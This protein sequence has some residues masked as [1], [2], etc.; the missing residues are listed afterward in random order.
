MQNV[1]SNL[2]LYSFHFF[3]SFVGF[4]QI[5]GKNA[6]VKRRMPLKIRFEAN[7]EFFNSLNLFFLSL[8]VLSKDCLE[9]RI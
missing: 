6:G 8:T 1:A 4:H 7:F 9:G 3:F 2:L 5:S